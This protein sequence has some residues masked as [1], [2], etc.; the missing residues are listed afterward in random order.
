MPTPS[1]DAPKRPKVR[2]LHWF[3]IL[4]IG[5]VALS[6]FH[7]PQFASKFDVFPGD[8]GDA[9]LVA[10]VME[11]WHQ[12]FKGEANWRSPAIFYPVE[13]SI[14]YADLM[15][16]YGIVHSVLRTF[17]LGIFEA[18]E[19]T[20]ILFN[21][22]N[23]LVCCV[24]LNKVLRFN[25][26][27]SIAG[28]AFFAF[29]SPKLVQLGHPQLQVIVFLPLA[30]IGILLLV[31]K[32]E[33][34]DRKHAF[35]LLV[36]SA[37]S[38]ALQLMTGFYAGW[39]FVFWS[40]LFLILTLLFTHTR[41]LVFDVV[42]RFW[43]S[44]VAAASVFLFA[45]I[46]FYLA[47][48]PVLRSAEPRS[49]SETLVLIPVGWSFLLMG[50][51]NYLWGHFSSPLLSSHSLSR[52]IEIGIGLI[53]TL[54]WLGLSVFAVWI[55]IKNLKSTRGVK[56]QLL[57]LSQLIIATCLVYLLGMRYWN[58]FSPWQFVYAYIPGA[59]AIRA[60]ARYSLTL[61]L[62]MA[63]AFAFV[64]D[65]LIG[66]ISLQTHS[67]RRT[68]LFACLFVLTTFGLVEQFGH[69]EDFDGFSISAE[70]QYLSRLSQS[71]PND[72]SVFYVGLTPPIIHNQFEYQ[73]DAMF[74]SI[75]KGLPT[76]NGYTGYLPANWGLFEVADPHYEE[77]VRRWINDWQIKGKVCRLF[78]REPKPS[79]NIY[80]S[81]VFV[82]QQYRD[83]L[84][85]DPDEE[86]F[87]MW[88]TKIDDSSTPPNKNSARVSLSLAFLESAE[89]L[90]NGY[91]VIRLY[92]ATLGRP[93]L[94][95]E[96]V[97]DF[98]SIFSS[99][100]AELESRKDA[101][102]TEFM[103]RS[104]F[105]SKYEGVSDVQFVKKLFATAEFPSTVRVETYSSALKSKKKT[106]A[107]VVRAVVDHSHTVGAFRNNAF[108]LMQ[109]FGHLNRDPMPAEYQNLLKTLNATG[110]YRQIIF[111]V[112]YSVEYRQRFGY[113]D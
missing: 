85:R 103:Q 112:L 37:L 34:L 9:R 80:D 22:L 100:K 39:F 15:V 57:I 2:I 7:I 16:G 8:R 41:N 104:E 59:Q 63:I 72:C 1:L 98:D 30:L 90:E 40:G 46:P 51:R 96:F 10:Y 82:R 4:A 78:I 27:A 44:M 62:P 54:A 43:P 53:A 88:L 56:P 83:I 14:G 108:V 25:L 93:P 42:K 55:L 67:K 109:F 3:L 86:G 101:L 33:T 91:F 23:Y 99:T 64:L 105:K 102:I 107:Q 38:L 89:F 48:L 75:L 24:L 17:G 76:L 70:K 68:L 110:D 111:D 32:R 29:N 69:K 87:H 58:D 66:K 60:V 81:K 74:V 94:Q 77:N 20:L 106:R 52:E 5:F 113:V 84:R 50:P 79:I 36:L 12:V 45:L 35:G 18:A 65:L 49:Y 61:A 31:Q 47:Y 97:N 19:L 95:E 6:Q 11:H 21:F 92:L 26:F 73:L 71:L 13:G 28:A